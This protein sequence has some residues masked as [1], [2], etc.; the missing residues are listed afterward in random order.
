M[1]VCCS[2]L[3]GITYSSE[4]NYNDDSTQFNGLL[5]D[6]DNKFKATTSTSRYENETLLYLCTQ[7]N[8]GKKYCSVVKNTSHAQRWA[9]TDTKW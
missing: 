3:L 6:R 8:R 1:C 9:H 7:H 2:F 5:N 4:L